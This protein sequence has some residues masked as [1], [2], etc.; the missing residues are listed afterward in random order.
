[1]GNLSFSEKRRIPIYDDPDQINNGI[2]EIDNDK[3]TGCGF[4]VKAC[5]ADA[6]F[7]ENKLS[8]MRPPGVN[9]CMGC[10]DCVAICPEDAIVATKGYEYT[11]FYKTIDRGYMEPPRL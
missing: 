2:V 4:C 8:K 3:C 7:M 1:M 10:G 5:P 6:L 9:E 11:G